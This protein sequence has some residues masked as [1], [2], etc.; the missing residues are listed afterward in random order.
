MAL[1]PMSFTTA[2]GFS[3]ESKIINVKAGFFF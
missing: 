3:E 2:C 1:T